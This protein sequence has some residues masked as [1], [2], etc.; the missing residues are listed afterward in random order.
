MTA[1]V[2]YTARTFRYARSWLSGDA[3]VVEREV[4]VDRGDRRVPA[5]LVLPTRGRAPY[6]AWIILHGVTRPGRAHPQLVRFVHAVAHAGSAVLVPEVPE[7]RR[8]HLASTRTLP[9]VLGAVEVLERLPDVAR[10][11]PGLMGFSFGAPQAIAI[12]GEEALAGRLAG[13]A[14]FG[15]FCDLERTL[16]FQL[17]GEHEWE[18]RHWRVRP[19]P[20]GRWIVGGNYLPRVPGHGD[21]EDV[22]AALHGLATEAGDRRVP[23]WDPV[24]DSL[25][26]RLRAAVAP[27]RRELFDLFAPTSDRDVDAAAAEPV[28][29][30][31]AATVAEIEPG[32]APGPRLDRVRVPVE[33]IH[34]RGDR[35]IPFTESLRLRKRLPDRVAGKVT[36]TRL[37]SHTR[38]DPLPSLL[39]RS[40]EG[41]VFAAALRRVL[42]TV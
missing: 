2:R 17:T 15:G 29:R 27:G 24:Y 33:L 36:V 21:A 34:G 6:P 8:L 18:G 35:L 4:D 3:D 38:G 14:G 9:T 13:V 25:I 23:S 10:G 28:V 12:S 37:F 39:R 30:A 1:M 32:L 19:D 31:L 20:Y 7:W 5:T 22:A 42:A 16:R 41:M 26:E 11:P 40:W